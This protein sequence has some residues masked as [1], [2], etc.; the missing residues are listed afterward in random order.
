MLTVTTPDSVATV[1]LGSM[2]LNSP[3]L[4]RAIN[5]GFYTLITSGG[6]KFTSRGNISSGRED[7]YGENSCS[8][9]ETRGDL[10]LLPTSVCKKNQNGQ[11]NTVINGVTLGAY[12]ATLGS[13]NDIII[14]SS[15]TMQVSL[16]YRSTKHRIICWRFH[17]GLSNTIELFQ[18]TT[19][20]SADFKTYS[21]TME[22]LGTRGLTKSEA[23]KYM[24]ENMAPRVDTLLSMQDPPPGTRLP[25]KLSPFLVQHD[26]YA[27]SLATRYNTRRYKPP[28][29]S[30]QSKIVSGLIIDAINSV[31]ALDMNG[32]LYLQQ[33]RQI[34]SLLPP[35]AELKGSAAKIKSWANVYLWLRY[36]IKLSIQATK[37]VAKGA[38]QVIKSLTEAANKKQR[39][40][41]RSTRV[42]ESHGDKWSAQY[43]V[44]IILSTYPENLKTVGRFI[45]TMYGFDVLPTLGN[46]W[47][48]YPYTFVVDWIIPVG[49]FLENVDTWGRTQSFTYHAYTQS[50]KYSR[51]VVLLDTDSYSVSGHAKHVIYNRHVSNSVP[52]WSVFDGIEAP[53]KPGFQRFVDAGSL[54]IQRT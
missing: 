46:L 49:N 32:M 20:F 19:S 40:R 37:K 16:H 4:G 30:E 53:G 12:A 23:I 17:C 5:F 47:D 52:T 18:Y 44:R 33:M 6:K 24:N 8:H 9:E 7:L 1:N 22:N 35:M 25:L 15:D 29:D 34:T 21:Q 39:V 26:A 54:I 51:D 14:S 13:S 42:L 43:S 41:S 45:D 3:K 50:V 48:M 38:P 31:D 28:F 27:A 36:G 11:E 2:N 10:V